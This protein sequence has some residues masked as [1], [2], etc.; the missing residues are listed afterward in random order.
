[1]KLA[2]AALKRTIRRTCRSHRAAANAFTRRQAYE[3][4]LTGLIEAIAATE[5]ARELALPGSEHYYACRDRHLELKRLLVCLDA[6][7]NALP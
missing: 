4:F 5:R 3:H 1:M 6:I 2:L 7:A